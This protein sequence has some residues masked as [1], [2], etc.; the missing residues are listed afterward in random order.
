MTSC[1]DSDVVAKVHQRIAQKIPEQEAHDSV[2]VRLVPRRL[3]DRLLPF[4]AKPQ[5]RGGM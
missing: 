3:I 4:V 1:I 2:I 5:N